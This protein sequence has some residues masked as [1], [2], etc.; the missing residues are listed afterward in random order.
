MVIR[1]LLQCG[2]GLL[3]VLRK[4]KLQTLLSPTQRDVLAQMFELQRERLVSFQDCLDNVRRKESTGK[5][6]PYIV[7]RETSLSGQ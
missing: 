2:L 1:D 6:V 3:R 5:D 4:S 7:R